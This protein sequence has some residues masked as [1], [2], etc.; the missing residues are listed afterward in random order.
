M[1]RARDSPLQDSHGAKDAVDPV[2]AILNFGYALLEA[3]AKIAC[4]AA[5]LDPH[6][7][8]C[9]PTA[10]RACLSSLISWSRYG[11]SWIAWC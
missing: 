11:H 7:G 2:N 4:H 8:S 3:E 5:G 1:F 10:T 9:T 6:S